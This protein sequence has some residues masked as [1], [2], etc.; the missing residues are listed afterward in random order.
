MITTSFKLF[1]PDPI[2][3][4]LSCVV[5]AELIY[6][7]NNFNKSVIIISYNYNWR[8]LCKKGIYHF[9]GQFSFLAESSLFLA[10][11]L[12]LTWKT[13]FRS[14]YKFVDLCFVFEIYLTMQ[15]IRFVEWET[16]ETFCFFIIYIL[17]MLVSYCC[18][19]STS[20]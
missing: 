3:Y 20:E 1:E 15:K 4:S 8:L 14:C 11:R 6:E 18:F 17:I 7:Q 10:D 12:V 5:F 13:S 19:V 16:K 9:L 2:A